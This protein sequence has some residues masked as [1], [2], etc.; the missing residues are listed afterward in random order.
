[1][2]LIDVSDWL[3]EQTQDDVFWYVKRLSANDTQATGGHQAGPYIPKQVLFDAIPSLYRPLAVNPDREF[4]LAID[5]HAD[6][7]TARAIWYNQ[8]T[9]NEA[10]VTGFGGSSSPLLDPY[11]TGALTVFA[12]RR[13]TDTHPPACHIWVCN[14]LLEEDVVES[15]IGPVEPG[16]WRTWPN[17]LSAL[18][19]PTDCRLS[20]EDIPPDWLDR[21]PTTAEMVRKT[22]EL[23]PEPMADVDLRLKRR[24]DCEY[25]LFL[26]V[27]EAIEFP[28]I[29]LGYKNMDEFLTHAQSVMQRRRARAGR[30]LELHVRQVLIEEDLVEGRNFDFQPLSEGRKRPDFLFPSAAAYHDP[31]VPADGLR[32]LGVKRTLR[33]RWRQ[34]IEEADR[35]G[36]KHLLTL[37]PEVSV[38]Q[39]TQMHEAGIELVVPESVHNDFLPAVRPHL[40]TLESFIADVRLLRP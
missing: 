37:D 34:V 11:S 24:H 17:L 27:E 29:A 30:S 36:T 33:E 26:S 28:R 25:Q 14:N 4:E 3:D 21:F 15:V 40:Q 16:E 39:L 23:R 1:M 12:F 38:P 10:R 19:K 9:R 8:K 31:A 6:I 32:M 2:P 18:V 13:E 22:I 5:S 35:I 20:R 7:R